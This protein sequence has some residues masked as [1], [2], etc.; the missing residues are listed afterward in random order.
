MTVD[1]ARGVAGTGAPGDPGS[2]EA[3][4]A[5]PPDAADRMGRD[6]A[7]QAAGTLLSRVT[8]FGRNFAF[9]YA[10]GATRLADTY[11]LA[12]TTPNIIYE[13]VLG[14]V[15]SGTLQPEFVR[16]LQPREGEDGWRDISAVF[17]LAIVASLVLSGLFV[18]VAPEL[19]R[20][21]TLRNKGDVGAEQLALAT[22]L[23]ILFAPQVLFYGAIS[24]STAL[25]QARRRFAAPAFAPVLNNAVV[26][27]MF[28]AYP[29]LVGSRD[30]GTVRSDRGAVLLLGLVTTAGVAAMAIAQ[31]PFRMARRHLRPVW[32]PRNPSVVRIV[33]LSGWTVA[34]VVTNQIA[35]FVVM[36]LANG[37]AGDVAVYFLANVIFLL[38][39]GVVAVS[40][41]TTVRTAMAEHLADDDMDGFRDQ[42]SLGIRAIAAVIVPAT[43]GLVILARPIVAFLL[44]HGALTKAG[45]HDVA[46]T[47]ALMSLGL[48]FFSVWLLIT[49]AFQALQDTRSLF[50]LYA[51]ENAA[52]IVAAIALYPSMGVAGLGLAFALSYVVGTVLGIRHLRRKVGSIRDR[53]TFESLGRVTIASAVMSAAVLGLTLVV[54]SNEGTGA[55]VR[56]GAGVVTGVTVYLVLARVLHIGELRALA[57]VRRPGR[58]R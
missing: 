17:T 56:A 36:F 12:N 20:L 43:A 18:L 10:L 3:V 33:R 19:I 6:V 40:I 30:L 15:L 31:F 23:L 39:H 4:A 27:A 1:D 2:A 7:V 11:T 32:E 22:D 25:L 34:F 16:R 50:W 38:P 57:P 29:T 28:L 41:I 54:G 5:V 49:S 48:P 55:V 42:M 35:L 47:L 21:Y 51:A 44:E 24:V 52:N 37:T 14:G 58:R 13:L 8:G 46:A 45:G 53:A 26:I 9:A